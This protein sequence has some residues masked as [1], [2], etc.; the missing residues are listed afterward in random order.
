MYQLY[1]ELCVVRT[2]TASRKKDESLRE[3]VDIIIKFSIP[4][5]W[6]FVSHVTLNDIQFVLFIVCLKM[7]RA[8]MKRRLFP[9]L[10]LKC[11][12]AGMYA[13]INECTECAVINSTHI[14]S[15]Y[16]LNRHI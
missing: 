3:R 12:F 1:A 10:T 7:Y 14:H 11:Y 15:V 9:Q 4:T 6:H 5:I 2:H 13:G 8:R 16:L